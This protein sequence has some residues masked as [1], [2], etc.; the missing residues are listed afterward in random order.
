ME[1][2]FI[3]LIPDKMFR[4]PHIPKVVDHKSKNT[5]NNT[6]NEFLNI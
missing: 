1:Q 3:K 6:P 2:N 4:K 5:I